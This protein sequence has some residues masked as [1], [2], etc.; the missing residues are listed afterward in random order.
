MKNNTSNYNYDELVDF[1]AEASKELG[2]SKETEQLSIKILKDA[3][4]KDIFPGTKPKGQAAAAIYIASILLKD[5]ISQKQIA[6][7]ADVTDSIVRKRY[8]DLVRE[9]QIKKKSK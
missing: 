8:I 9:L 1:I 2:L 4:H 6:Q 3:K 7:L 5:R